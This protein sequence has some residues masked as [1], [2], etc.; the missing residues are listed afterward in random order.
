MREYDTSAEDAKS[1]RGNGSDDWTPSRSHSIE[2]VP[3]ALGFLVVT[4]GD[5][6][7]TIFGATNYGRDNDSIAGMGGAIA[8]ALHGI[9]ALRPEWVETINSANRIDLMPLADDL[10]ALTR[11]L[12]SEQ[13]AAAQARQAA[14]NELM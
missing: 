6:E 8:G 3:I 13:L 11:K 4:G 10:A 5:F 1:E 7:E 9:D 14:F 2:E 12:Q